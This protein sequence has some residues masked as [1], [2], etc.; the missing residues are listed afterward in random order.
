M[1]N[2]LTKDYYT[3]YFKITEPMFTKP[4][5]FRIVKRLKGYMTVKNA[6]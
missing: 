2:Q 3:E 6:A 5:E 1:K 4:R